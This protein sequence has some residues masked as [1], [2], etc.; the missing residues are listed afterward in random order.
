MHGP[1]RRYGLIGEAFM[2]D[3]KPSRYVGEEIDGR[4]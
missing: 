1:D 2:G 3:D 4:W